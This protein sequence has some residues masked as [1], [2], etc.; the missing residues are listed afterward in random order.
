M[1]ISRFQQPVYNLI[2]RLLNDPADACDAVQEVFL[3][4]FRNVESFR[5]QSSLKTWVYRIAL[6]EAYN[7]R[8]WFSRH[9]KQEV[10][11]ETDE[12]GS[13]SW[14]ESISDPARDPYELT[15]NE[16]RH[17]LIEDAL[18]EINPD[19]RA[20]VVLRDLEELSY[21]EIAEV[22]QVSL[23]TVK[24]R[25]LRGRESLRRVLVAKANDA[26]A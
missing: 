21:E 22:M 15:L 17:Q 7:H 26:K 19:F 2:Y 10:G 13:R 25:I 4:V 23:G 14:I 18:R 5:G 11:L 20:A 3:K 6:N 8:R 24:S 16:E 9:R 1:L 12:E